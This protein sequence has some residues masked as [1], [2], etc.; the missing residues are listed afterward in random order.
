MRMRGATEATSRYRSL[1]PL[2]LAALS[3]VIIATQLAG[4]D[5]GGHWDEHWHVNAVKNSLENG[6]LLPSM[7]IY[8]SFIY[9]CGIFLAALEG[10]RGLAL[11]IPFAH[12]TA[13]MQAW[14]STLGFTLLWRAFSALLSFLTVLWTYACLKELRTSPWNAVFGAALVATSWEF[15]YHSRFIAVDTVTAQFTILSLLL[16]L[17]FCR[18]WR[19]GWLVAAAAAA[20]F[21]TGTKYPGLISV[22][23]PLLTL[24]CAPHRNFPWRLKLLHSVSLGAVCVAAFLLTT[25]GA[26]LNFPLFYEHVT[27]MARVNGS[28]DGL[29]IVGAG[30][31][32]FL[33]MAEYFGLASLSFNSLGACGAFLLA[34]A[35]VVVLL[36]RDPRIALVLLS[37]PIGYVCFFAQQRLMNV[38][39]LMLVL[40]YL[41]IFAALGSDALTRW[42][43]AGDADLVRRAVGLAMASAATLLIS[44]NTAWLVTT[45]RSIYSPPTGC[46]P[47]LL[48]QY[49]G[50]PVWLSAMAADEASRSNPPRLLSLDNASYPSAE[51]LVLFDAREVTDARTYV[52]NRHDYIET[53]CGSREI[54][55]NYYPSWATFMKHPWVLVLRWKHARAMSLPL[56]GRVVSDDGGPA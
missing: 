22:V 39:N 26:I 17:R 46:V 19:S 14:T 33:R 7:F 51:D 50:R 56:A 21:S 1:P 49:A 3:G 18:S 27:W 10:V 40:P 25:P 44:W 24:W 16:T 23:T 31:E 41:A 35:G 38:R 30:R 43:R 48:E 36:R 8:P 4:L 29:Q 9:V 53:W 45:A 2:G 34:I 13:D 15:C 6:T 11:G 28:G 5:F 54:N 12:L 20:G 37:V 32:H 42:S 52:F 55:L 47:S